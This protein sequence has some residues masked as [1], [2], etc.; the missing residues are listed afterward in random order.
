MPEHKNPKKFRGR[1]YTPKYIVNNILDMA[2]YYG[3]AILGKHI[4]DNS[5]GDGAFLCEIVERYCQVATE[6]EVNAFELKKQLE[7]YIHGIEIDPTEHKKCLKNLSVLIEKYNIP[8]NI[9]WDIICADTLKVDQYNG[10]MDYV[11]GNPPYVRVHNLDDSLNMAKEY[12]FA[13]SGMTDLYIVFYEI[14]L[15][16]LNKTGVLGY[17]SPS[18]FFNSLAGTHMRRYLTENNLIEKIVDLKHYQAFDSTT[19]TTIVILN[20]K[21]DTQN[22]EYYQFDSKNLIPYYVETLSVDDYYIAKKFYFSTKS[23]LALLKKILLNSRHCDIEVKNGYATLC[24]DVFVGNFEFSSTHII[25]A[26]KASRGELKQIIYPYDYSGK[27]IPEKELITDQN[28]YQYLLNHK[29]VLL[30]RSLEN[31][32]K[33]LWYA[34]GRSQAIHDTYKDKIAINALLRTSKDLKIIHAPPGTGVYS[35]LYLISQKLDFNEVKAAFSCDEFSI[36][37]SLLGKYKS[38]GYYTFSSKDIKNYLDY[39]LTESGGLQQ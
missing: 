28:L 19:Y 11:L 27:L 18:S 3:T 6:N 34:Y 32:N 21:H 10:K 30:K 37:I 16:M 15:K 33:S 36:Y 29:D 38:G 20:K 31:K 13:Q 1:I 39:K 23:N 8:T 4:I 5:C 9:S 14:G 25:P 7:T 2:H 22:V 24:D 12:S 17:I 26:V 35:G